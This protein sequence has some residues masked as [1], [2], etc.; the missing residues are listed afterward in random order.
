MNK[1]CCF[2]PIFLYTY[3]RALHSVL[4]NKICI[5]PCHFVMTR[6]QLHPRPER[7][8]QPH[9]LGVLLIEFFEL[10]GRKFNYVKTAIRVKSGGCYVSKDELQKVPAP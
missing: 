9:N 2:F 1:F 6:L 3:I 8:R 7:L 10:Y 4:L 5:S